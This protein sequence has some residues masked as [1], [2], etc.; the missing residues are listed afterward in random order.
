MAMMMRGGGFGVR[1]RTQARICRAAGRMWANGSGAAAPKL[2]QMN[3]DALQ[4]KEN[5]A[6]K[7]LA[8]RL[9]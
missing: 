7:V 2:G 8:R 9:T 1:E 3:V 5:A 4:A 6:D